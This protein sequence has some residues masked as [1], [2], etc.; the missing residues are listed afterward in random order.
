MYSEVVAVRHQTVSLRT[1]II[2][3]DERYILC[4]LYHFVTERNPL[5]HLFYYFLSCRQN[6]FQPLHRH[7]MMSKSGQLSTVTQKRRTV[8]NSLTRLVTHHQHPAGWEREEGKNPGCIRSLVRVILIHLPKKC[9][10][11]LLQ[12][13]SRLMLLTIIM[14]SWLRQSR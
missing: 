10:M 1:R 4:F 11:Y 13:T 2:G 5:S 8:A 6:L 7:P 9:C 14:T 12:M 3:L